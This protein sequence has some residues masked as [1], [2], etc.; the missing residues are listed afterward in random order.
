MTTPKIMKSAR[1][2]RC[3]IRLPGCNGGFETTVFAHVD[4]IRFGKGTGHK[5]MFGAYG[6]S[7]CHD[8]VDGRKKVK[9]MSKPEIH[10]FHVEGVLETWMRLVEKGLVIL[11]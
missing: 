5:S 11:K 2:E 8:I 4:K 1:E 6:C 3:T 10:L 7:S 9:G